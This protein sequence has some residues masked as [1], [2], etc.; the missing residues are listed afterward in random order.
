M[1]A[2][3]RTDGEPTYQKS[4]DVSIRNLEIVVLIVKNGLIGVPISPENLNRDFGFN[5]TISGVDLW[6]PWLKSVG[7]KLITQIN[8][9]ELL[10]TL[11]IEK[12]PDLWFNSYP[13]EKQRM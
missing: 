12:T 10:S 13:V 7:L 5:H 9:L 11:T 3:R 8:S 2:D 4:T 6:S 1:P